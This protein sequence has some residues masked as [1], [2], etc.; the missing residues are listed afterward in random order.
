M[1]VIDKDSKTAIEYATIQYYKNNSYV[2]GSYS[3]IH[4]IFSLLKNSD[5]IIISCIGYKTLTHESNS[6]ST[7]I[8][9]EKN[10]YSLEEVVVG[11]KKYIA[12]NIDKKKTKMVG[13]SMG[14]ETGSYIKN[15]FKKEFKVKSLKFK[16]NKVKDDVKYRIHFYSFKKDTLVPNIELTTKNKINTLTK[17]TKGIIEINLENENIIFPLE[18]IYITLECLSGENVPDNKYF[19]SK[20]EAIF[21]IEAYKSSNFEFVSRNSLKGVGWINVNEWLPRN[22][23]DTF[24]KDY[25]IGLLYVPTFGLDLIEVE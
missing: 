19:L 5:K 24:G 8:E 21:S 9:L 17:N 25:D 15:N 22:Y 12:G 23:K 6:K 1:T 13:L 11:N 20:K 14:L 10:I 4:G 16:V 18:G 2:N 7:V 3:D